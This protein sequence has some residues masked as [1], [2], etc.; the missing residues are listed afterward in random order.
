MHVTAAKYC[1]MALIWL[2]GFYLFI[3][4]LFQSCIYLDC[5]KISTSYISKS[6][7]RIKNGMIKCY[8]IHGGRSTIINLNKP[9]VYIG[10]GKL[11][12]FFVC[13]QLKTLEPEAIQKFEFFLQAKYNTETLIL[14]LYKQLFPNMIS[15]LN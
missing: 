14:S 15:A 9:V 7:I 13:Q 11:L 5:L 1:G 12:D 8:T 6:V 3:Y 10:P 4:L 2:I